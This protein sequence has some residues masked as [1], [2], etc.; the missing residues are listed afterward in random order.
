MLALGAIGGTGCAVLNAAGEVQN[1]FAGVKF[2]HEQSRRMDALDRRIAAGDVE[3]RTEQAAYWLMWQDSTPAQVAGAVASLERAADLG[4]PHAQALLG[5]ILLPGRTLEWRSPRLATDPER[6]LHLLLQAATKGCKYSAHE[7]TR[8]YEVVP[9]KLLADYYDKRGDEVQRMIWRAR[10]VL[11]CAY[12]DAREFVY[13][14]AGRHGGIESNNEL[15]L[16]LLSGDTASFDLIAA[17]VS[18]KELAAADVLAADLR[19]L[20]AASEQ[21]YPAP[22]A[23]AKAMSHP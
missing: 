7:P 12:P 17:K 11:H 23:R 19:R 2:R 22:P 18:A 13:G 9:T 3:A 4:S 15:A 14:I 8:W 1:Q 20:V 5:D 16:L 21:Q 6:G 10:G